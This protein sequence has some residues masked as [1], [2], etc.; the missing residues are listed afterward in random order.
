[1]DYEQDAYLTAPSKRVG[2]FSS[3]EISTSVE[4]ATATLLPVPKNRA[5]PRLILGSTHIPFD[6]QSS[7]P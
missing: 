2:L 1:M 6:T 4:Y 7:L 5:N 3:E